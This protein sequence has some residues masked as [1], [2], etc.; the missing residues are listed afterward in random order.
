MRRRVASVVEEVHLS[1]VRLVPVDLVRVRELLGCRR[2]LVR[3][4]ADPGR[5]RD[6]RDRVPR[7]LVVPRVLHRRPDVLQVRQVVV[8]QRLERLADDEAAESIG[9]R[10]EDVEV[11]GTGR[12]LRDRLVERRE[13][14]LLDLDAVLL[15]EVLLDPRPEVAVPVV[16]AKCSALG[17]EPRRDHRVVVEQRPR[18]GAVGLGQQ[19]LGR[20]EVPVVAATA[21]GEERAQARQADDAGR[22]PPEELMAA[23]PRL[24][25]MIAS[26]PP[27]HSW[28]PSE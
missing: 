16:D 7:L 6:V 14:R 10:E 12:D 23:V 18:D 27:G 11:D 2:D 13:E 28:P 5:P 24:T 3:A 15:G 22:R 4:V 1:A 25:W 9:C 21:G 20:L 26:Q 17:L 8:V 19:E